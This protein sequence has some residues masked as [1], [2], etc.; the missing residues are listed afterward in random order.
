MMNETHTLFRTIPALAACALALQ[1]APGCS[2]RAAVPPEMAPLPVRVMTVEPGQQKVTKRFSGYTYPWEAAGVGFLIGGRVTAI[3]VREGDH[4][5]KGQVLATIDPQDYALVEQLTEAQVDAIRPNY[6]RVVGLIQ[7]DA[8]PRARLDEVQGMY[9]A[10]MTQ[11]RQAQRQLAY[12]RLQAPIDGVVM[13]KGTSVGQVIGPGMPAVIVLN[14]TKIKVKFGVTQ[15]ELELFPDGT[16]VNVAIDGV[17]GAV[18]GRVFHVALV[19]DLTTRLYEVTLEIANQ[20]ERLRPG[21][22]SRIEMDVRQ[23]DGIF[24]PLRAVKRNSKHEQV[25]YL[26]GGDGLVVERPVRIGDL[27]GEMIQIVEGLSRGENLIVEGQAFVSP[28][29]KV[30]VL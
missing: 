14:L 2:S 12:T 21:M 4:V 6:E 1:V 3:N 9:R 5:R 23:A 27:F 16:D 10:A 28:G 25:V 11:N 29:E 15:R 7:D 20:D 8:L 24:I 17:S 26:V 30:T 18:T 13:E 19:P 22:L